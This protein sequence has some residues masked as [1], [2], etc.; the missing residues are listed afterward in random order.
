MGGDG[1]D[2]IWTGAGDDTI[3]GGADQDSAF[4]DEGNDTCTSVEQG[5]QG[6]PSECEVLNP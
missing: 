3:D 6:E 2:D 1:E 4:A 5:L